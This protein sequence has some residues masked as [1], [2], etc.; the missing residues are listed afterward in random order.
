MSGVKQKD[1]AAIFRGAELHRREVR[2]QALLNE[3]A[4]E[5]EALDQPAQQAQAAAV[6]SLKR[7]SAAYLELIQPPKPKLGYWRR[8][9]L[10]IINKE[11]P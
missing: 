6:E 9:W 5:N 8:L 3:A 4:L 10:A 7:Q 1:I 2:R 11:A